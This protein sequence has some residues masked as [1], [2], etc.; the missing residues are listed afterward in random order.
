MNGEELTFFLSDAAL[1]VIEKAAEDPSRWL[2]SKHGLQPGIARAI[3]DCAL[4]WKKAAKKFDSWHNSH[5]RYTRL[6]FEQSSSIEVARLNAGLLS[7]DLVIDACGGLGFDSLA[8]LESG[9][10]LIHN[11]ID[12]FVSALARH[13][14]SVSGFIA[15]FEA[16]AAEE[17][18]FPEDPDIAI[19]LDPSRR[20]GGKSVAALDQLS[21]NPEALLRHIPV[22]TPVL[23]KLSPMYDLN[24]LRLL[25]FEATLFCVSSAG[26]NRE[27]LWYR[28]QNALPAV[29][30][31]ILRKNR[32][33]LIVS[34]NDRA[35][36][37][38][39]QESPETGAFI[40]VPDAAIVH[41]RLVNEWGAEFGARLLS[42]NPVLVQSRKFVESGGYSG[43]I[44]E[45]GNFHESVLKDVLAHYKIG[46]LTLRVSEREKNHSALRKK[47]GVKEGENWSL[48]AYRDRKSSLKFILS[49][50]P[51]AAF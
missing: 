45:S 50:A 13:N 37:L 3:A 1:P 6:G 26:E 15:G 49:K 18:P 7:A 17:Y 20:K 44:V 23:I 19:F 47:L 48:I 16:T 14:I 41:A 32:E 35:E 39:T 21:P 24:E 27:V 2:L 34:K 42:S 38:E 43:E 9:K 12:P 5:L 36:T 22:K 30:A 29:N 11:E 28:H 25:P 51:S 33:P 40:Y 10:S 4:V 31:I 8:F 46:G